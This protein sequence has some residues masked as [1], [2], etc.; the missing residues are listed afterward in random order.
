MPGTGWILLSKNLESLLIPELSSHYNTLRP[1]QYTSPTALK[2]PPPKALRIHNVGWGMQ[3]GLL[4]ASAIQNSNQAFL[5]QGLAVENS[6]DHIRLVREM[7]ADIPYKV[8][9]TFVVVGM[10]QWSSML[11]RTRSCPSIIMPASSF[12][13]DDSLMAGLTVA[14][15]SDFVIDD[16]NENPVAD[17]DEDR[18]AVSTMSPPIS[19]PASS[20]TSDG[21]WIGGLTSGVHQTRSEAPR[22]RWADFSDDEDDIPGDHNDE[23][24]DSVRTLSEPEEEPF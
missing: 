9:N 16:G 10:P 20:S 7:F 1:C 19:M 14:A 22:P 23:D 6:E 21:S 13:S 18:V 17:R 8:K 24:H 11:R 3:C 4:F 12:T 5:V 15:Q 2:C